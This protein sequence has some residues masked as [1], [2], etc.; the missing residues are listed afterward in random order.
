MVYVKALCMRA[1]FQIYENVCIIEG[2]N[3]E[4]PWVL[5]SFTRARR[6]SL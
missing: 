4:Y 3:V 6:P 5:F 2:V 1:I